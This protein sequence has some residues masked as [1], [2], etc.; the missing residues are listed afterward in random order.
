M[1]DFPERD[2]RPSAE[3]IQPDPMLKERRSAGPL[4]IAFASFFAVLIVA[5]VFYGLNQARTPMTA[6]VTS[7]EPTT[8]GSAPAADAPAPSDKAQQQPANKAQQQPANEGQAP[9]K[10]DEK[11]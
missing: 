7:S 8:S 6:T 9:A 5:V 4:V 1:A 11:R 10:P 2:P 3:H